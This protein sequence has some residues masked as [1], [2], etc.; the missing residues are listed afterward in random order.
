MPRGLSTG[1]AEPRTR[2]EPGRLTRSQLLA[3]ASST[4]VE[5]QGLEGQADGWKVAG[6]WEP[7]THVGALS[8]IVPDAT[9]FHPQDLAASLDTSFDIAVRPGL[10]CAPY[11]HRNLGTFPDGTLRLSPGPFNTA[12]DIDA[13]L[14]ALSEI[15]AGVF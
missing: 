8:L 14:G 13:F 9:I 11:I 4:G 6:R 7:A 3:E 2:V 1:S 10:H 5:F 12:A 15:T